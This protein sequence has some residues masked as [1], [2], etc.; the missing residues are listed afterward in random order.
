MRQRV[1]LPVGLAVHGA[2]KQLVVSNGRL[3]SLLFAFL[4]VIFGCRY[5]D[6]IVVVFVVVAV[7][8]VDIR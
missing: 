2:Q 7:F 6:L 8:V 3:S 4:A 5:V 1:R